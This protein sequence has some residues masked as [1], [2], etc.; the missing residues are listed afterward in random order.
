MLAHVAVDVRTSRAVVVRRVL[1]DL[2]VVEDEPERRSGSVG[3]LGDGSAPDPSLTPPTRRGELVRRQD[4]K[5]LPTVPAG[6][7][8]AA[9]AV[10][11]FLV[12]SARNGSATTPGAT[13]PRSAEPP[14][15]AWLGD[16]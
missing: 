9:V 16:R 1:S 14:E 5:G 12:G 11:L 7:G 13:V 3:T 4:V 15:R 10:D 6:G 8:V 2:N